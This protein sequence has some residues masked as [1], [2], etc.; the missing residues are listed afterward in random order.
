MCHLLQPYAIDSGTEFFF[1]NT[2]RNIYLCLLHI[3]KCQCLNS[4]EGAYLHI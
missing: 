3:G 4:N 1:L 2:L